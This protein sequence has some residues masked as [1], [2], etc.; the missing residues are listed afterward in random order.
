MDVSNLSSFNLSVFRSYVGS[1]LWI[2]ALFGADTSLP[3]MRPLGL[4]VLSFSVD[5]IDDFGIL[6]ASSNSI[7]PWEFTYQQLSLKL[8]QIGHFSAG[9]DTLIGAAE[10]ESYAAPKT[11]CRSFI[12]RR[13]L[14]INLLFTFSEHFLDPLNG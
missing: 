5:I 7:L 10:T 4:I 9:G 13:S 12:W 6:G 14:D 1:V 2:P 8:T 11:M 3:L